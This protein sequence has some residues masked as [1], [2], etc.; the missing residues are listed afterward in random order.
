MELISYEAVPNGYGQ[1][2]LFP[3]LLANKTNTSLE[4]WFTNYKFLHFCTN[5]DVEKDFVKF[6]LPVEFSYSLRVRKRTFNELKSDVKTLIDR[7][8]FQELFRI[9]VSTLES[10]NEL[11]EVTLAKKIGGSVFD[12][13]TKIKNKKR[14]FHSDPFPKKIRKFAFET[15]FKKFLEALIAVNK[16]RNCYEHRDGILG[17]ED[18]NDGN[19]L[20][21][22][23]RFPT[24]VS[25]D[26]QITGVFDSMPI[27]KKF[28]PQIV[29]RK[30]TFR[31]NDRLDLNF[32]DSYRLI[33]S[34]N[35]ALKGI[36]DHLY[37]CNKIE[38]QEIILKQFQ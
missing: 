32:N 20:V 3:L 30:R 7:S 29:E 26:G 34:I 31:I 33:Y 9:L 28:T 14:A 22:N 12:L 2:R 18:C 17:K 38:K 15:K 5:Q 25:E 11:H 8:L 21:L 37:A 16:A 24:S 27:C 19:R 36:I 23:L 13:R 4:E 10:A 6:H 1:I 35:F